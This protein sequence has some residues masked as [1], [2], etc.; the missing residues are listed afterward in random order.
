MK[1]GFLAKSKKGLYDDKTKSKK[2]DP[3]AK[4]SIDD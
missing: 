4:V 2:V 1:G 3:N